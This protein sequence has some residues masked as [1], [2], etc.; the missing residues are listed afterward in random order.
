MT[1]LGKRAYGSESPQCRVICAVDGV[2]F[3]RAGD[4]IR[5]CVVVWTGFVRSDSVIAL[6]TVHGH[7]PILSDTE[8]NY[9]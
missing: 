8:T 1:P 5:S 2:W 9:T 3:D 6:V 7:L 4:G